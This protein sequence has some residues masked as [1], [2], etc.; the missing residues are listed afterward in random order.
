MDA[1]N[2]GSNVVIVIHAVFCFLDVFY[3]PFGVFYFVNKQY[4]ICT[5]T[6]TCNELS[7]ESYMGTEFLVMFFAMVAQIPIF[8]ALLLIADVLKD[9]GKF[10]DALALLLVPNYKF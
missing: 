10:S 6:D 2:A 9:G 4:F 1:V 8:S 7:W 5:F 3:I